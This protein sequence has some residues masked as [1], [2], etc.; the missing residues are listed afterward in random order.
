MSFTALLHIFLHHTQTGWQSNVPALYTIWLRPCLT[1]RIIFPQQTYPWN[2]DFTT[3]VWKCGD[4]RR[5]GDYGHRSGS[6]TQRHDGSR[7][8]STHCDMMHRHA[9]KRHQHVVKGG[10][11]MKNP[12]FQ[13]PCTYI[14][15]FCVPS[16]WKT[17]KYVDPVS[18]FCSACFRK[19]ASTSCSGFISFPF[20]Q[21]AHYIYPIWVSSI[22][23]EKISWIFMQKAL[24]YLWK[25][26]Q[27]EGKACHKSFLIIHVTQ[28]QCLNTR[29]PTLPKPLPL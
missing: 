8:V 9:K 28:L 26:C 15:V 13:C 3:Q 21:W 27:H 20:S 25:M 18:F 2:H 14:L 24:P 7:G 6:G 10:L 19:R 16:K 23:A 17:L 11:I 12:L 4:G 29:G 1:L 5:S 22:M